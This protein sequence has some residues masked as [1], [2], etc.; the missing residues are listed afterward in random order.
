MYIPIITRTSKIG[1]AVPVLVLSV[2]A[3]LK[4]LVLDKATLV[5]KI[6]LK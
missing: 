3:V 6:G 5:E 2:K 1:I 4:F